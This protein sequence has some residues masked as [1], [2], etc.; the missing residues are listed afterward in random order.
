MK[1]NNIF[2]SYIVP[3]YNVEKYLPRC[4]ESLAKQKIKEGAGIE[5]ILVNDGSKDESLRLLKEF[6]AD[7]NRVIIIDQENQ[8]VSAARNNGLKIAKGKY[9]YFHDGDDYL[10][11]EASQL[12][13]DEYVNH[14]SDIIIS[15]AFGVYEEDLEKKH[16]WNT[17]EG[18]CSGIYTTQ[19]FIS[20]IEKLPISFKTYKRELLLRNNVLFDEDLKV[21]EVYVFFIHALAFSKYVTLT[22][23]RMTNY[24]IRGGGALKECNVNRDGNII[25][26]LHRIDKYANEFIFDIKS[27]KSYNYSLTAIVNKFSL[28]KY[29][30]VTDYTREIGVFLEN[31]RKDA[32]YRKSLR[33]LIKNPH[34]NKKYLYV[35]FLYIFPIRFFYMIK[36]KMR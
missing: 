23:G 31:V 11:D 12:M 5:Y 19:A 26:A 2:I 14:D 21:G 29:P 32:I 24:V 25:D 28:Y 30:K 10:T 13:Y 9:V 36:R 22:D 35:V 34:I 1:E 7:D 33:Y 6:A 18:I 4:L 17:F 27:K 3:C 8:G 16:Y 15:N 20:K